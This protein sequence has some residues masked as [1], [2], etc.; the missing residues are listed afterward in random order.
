MEAILGLLVLVAIILP[1]INLSNIKGLRKENESLRSRVSML[2]AAWQEAGESAPQPQVQAAETRAA[3]A[4][5]PLMEPWPPLA[6]EKPVEIAEEVPSVVSDTRKMFDDAEDLVPESSIEK[7][8]VPPV[9]DKKKFS[10]NYSFKRSQEARADVKEVRGARNY[11][12]ERALKQNDNS[13]EM[14]LATKLPVWIGAICLIFAGFYLVK[15][16]IEYGLLTDTVRLLLG[17]S[18]AAGLVAVG[19][20]IGLRPQIANH[21]RLAQGLIGAGIV[22]LFIAFYAAVNLYD[23]LSA[24]AGFG[25]MTIVTAIAV[26]LSLRHGQAIA[27]FGII[28]GALTPALVASDAPNTLALFSYLYVLFGGVCAVMLRQK[29]WGLG[30]FA[31]V[32]V[33]LWTFLWLLAGFDAEESIIAVFFML[34]T[35]G[36][37]L[38]CTFYAMQNNEEDTPYALHALNIVAIAGAVGG[39]SVLSQLISF[40][41]FDWAVM[42]LLSAGLMALTCFNSSLYKTPL[43]LKLGL[44]L[45]LLYIWTQVASSFEIL[46]VIAIFAA[47]YIGG[48]SALIRLG[49]HIKIWAGVQVASALALTIVA[50]LSPV[51]P[52]GFIMPDATFWGILSLIGAGIFALQVKVAGQRDLPLEDINVLKAVYAVGASVFLSLSAY[53]MLPHYYLSLAIAGQALVTVWI[54]TRINL[55]FLKT[56]IGCLLVAF[57]ALNYGQFLLFADI[58]VKSINGEGVSHSI[59][60]RFVLDAPLIK[61]GIPAALFVLSSLWLLRHRKDETKLINCFFGGAIAMIVFTIYYGLCSLFTPENQTLFTQALGFIERGWITALVMV[62]GIAAVEMAKRFDADYLFGWGKVLVRL[63]LVRIVFFDLFLLNPM[64]HGEQNVGEMALFNGVSLT[65][66]VGLM[67]CI[68]ALYNSERLKHSYGLKQM[69]AIVGFVC[70]LA[71]TS[72]NIRQY[73]HGGNLEAGAASN[74]E[75]YSYSAIWLITGFVVLAI[76]IKKRIKAIRLAA[77]GFVGL[78]VCK[79]FLFDAGDLEGLWRVGA[80]LGLGLSLMGLSFFYTRFVDHE[81]Q[82]AKEL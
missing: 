40:G 26:I 69:A 9:S 56:I 31:L 27:V 76:G 73:F 18:F 63:A 12:D 37:V 35:V 4:A 22:G 65:Y 13:V 74:A 54:F 50:A 42:A 41:I 72:M 28:G 80:F 64:M 78:T 39:M 30:I 53:L 67:G 38:G 15:Y 6:Q 34:G 45:G 8:P 59:A 3:A 60:N 75:Q 11:T 62:S 66:G 10:G 61:L 71:L 14:N 33:Y 46:S 77:L 70:L 36:A 82:E 1:W 43:F 17:G 7:T 48:S 68:W 20:F 24:I 2:E 55:P 51:L 52:E 44:D 21:Q 49:R 32:L 57:A 16:S 19:H 25:A 79:V 23:L 58:F 5:A 81:Q 47:L 29:W